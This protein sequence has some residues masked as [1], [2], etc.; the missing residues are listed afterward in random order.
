M[1]ERREKKSEKGNKKKE[2][3]SEEKH[4]KWVRCEKEE[5]NWVRRK[6]AKTKVRKVQRDC[7]KGKLKR[8][9]EKG[10]KGARMKEK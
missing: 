4:K 9:W 5:E 2:G 10:V 6:G 8:E 1:W 3:K 7:V